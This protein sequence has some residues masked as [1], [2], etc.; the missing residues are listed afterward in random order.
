M[1][2]GGDGRAVVDSARSDPEVLAVVPAWAEERESTWRGGSGLLDHAGRK[3][4]SR[5]IHRCT[6]ALQQQQ[7]LATEAQEIAE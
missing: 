6:V 7:G 1:R 5:A 2:R 3:A 4:G